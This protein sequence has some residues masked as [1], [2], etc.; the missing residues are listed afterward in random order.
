MSFRSG[1]FMWSAHTAEF[2]T[3]SCKLAPV[4]ELLRHSNS[5]PGELTGAVIFQVK[6]AALPAP[7]RSSPATTAA[8]WLRDWSATRPHSA[9]TAQ[10]SRNAKTVSRDSSNS[11]YLKNKNK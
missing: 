9:A 11:A 8:V 3:N 2:C 7:R 5:C 10:T 6:N 1:L 4:V